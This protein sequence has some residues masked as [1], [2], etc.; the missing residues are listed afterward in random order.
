MRYSLPAGTR[1]ISPLLED[2]Q[3]QEEPVRI[4][5]ML[6]MYFLLM[7]TGNPFFT[8][9]YDLI[10]M[11][12]VVITIYYVYKNAHR[13]ISYRTIFIFVFLL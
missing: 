7:L 5:E 6:L 3:A 8:T 13:P 2:T 10:V 12:S 11:L 9:W 4:P 1:F